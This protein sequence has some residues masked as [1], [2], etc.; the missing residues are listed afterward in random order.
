LEGTII[1]LEDKKLEGKFKLPTGR[2]NWK[3]KG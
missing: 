3:A 1:Q 2:S